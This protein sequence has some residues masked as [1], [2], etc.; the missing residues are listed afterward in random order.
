MDEEPTSVA[1][2]R[3][4]AAPLLRI[5]LVGAAAAAL[6]AVGILAAA[7]SAAPGGILAADPSASPAA[8]AATGT[9]ARPAGGP[10]WEMGGRGGMRSG[11]IT[12]T[13]IS[14]SSISLRTTDGWTRTITPDSG[15]TVQKGGATAALADLK[16]GDE[17]QFKETRETNGT[18]TIDAITVIPPHAG[19]TVSAISGSTITV[20]HPD[21]SSA[22]IKVG[23]TTT[24]DVAGNAGAKLSDLKT[25]MVVNATGTRNS[26]GSLTAT[27][28][29]AFD[30]AA[31]PFGG[32]HGFGH[33]F[34]GD[35]DGGGPNAS[36]AP[37]ATSTTTGG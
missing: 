1:V 20:T 16:V 23:S 3:T 15:T 7:T 14:G 18:Y 27:A 8:S 6:V 2:Q 28:V 4:G 13:A 21:G 22:T 10:G 12:I 17:I 37:S 34:P 5:G 29:R 9:H 26:D 35:N 30:P 19:G 11:N 32:H 24:Y 36:A 33:G 31:M 25:G